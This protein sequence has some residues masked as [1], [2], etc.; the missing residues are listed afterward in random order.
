[1][2]H[3]LFILFVITH[4]LAGLA[5]AQPEGPADDLLL[6]GG[7]DAL[8]G[9][10]QVQVVLRQPEGELK[11]STI[12]WESIQAGAVSTVSSGGIKIVEAQKDE[13]KAEPADL[14]ELRIDVQALELKD[15]QNC[16]FCVRTS[17]A[18]MVY[19]TR[20][21]KH[22]IKTNVWETEPTMEIV[23][24]QTLPDAIEKAVNDQ[25]KAFVHSYIMSNPKPAPSAVG[26]KSTVVEEKQKTQ[27][28]PAATESVKYPYAASKN[29]GIFHKAECISVAKI[30][31]ENLTGYK[32]R[33][34]A[35]QAGKRPCKRC[36]P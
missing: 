27:P 8:K 25:A 36:Q 21:L 35:L 32:T 1:M 33:D 20:D 28:P 24:A 15:S 12:R 26:E 34:E 13:R 9:I 30:K 11:T 7:F 17:L 6:L 2:R 19:L 16:V 23:P 31:P 18:R 22:A 3:C 14:V 10:E 4:I 29:S 5:A